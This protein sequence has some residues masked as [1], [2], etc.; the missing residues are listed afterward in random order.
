VLAALRALPAEAAADPAAA[1]KARDGTLAYLEKRR[2]Q[3]A[4]ARFAG[5]G[6]PIGSGLVESANK[7]VVEARLKGAGMHWAPAHVDAMA[8]LRTVVCA[9]RW[10]DAWPLVA[11][12]LRARTR[13]P[14]PCAPRGLS[15]H[16]AG[17]PAPHPHPPRRPRVAPTPPTPDGHRPSRSWRWAF[18]PAVRAKQRAERA[19]SART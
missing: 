13:P 14:R 17:R 16:Q 6:F 7:L 11:A 4:Y 15:A 2:E 9:D 1:A 3:V 10:D 19:T 18:Q 5:C 8:A 12:R